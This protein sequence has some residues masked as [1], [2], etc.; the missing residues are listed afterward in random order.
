MTIP[1][2]AGMSWPVLSLCDPMIM[3]E[4][5]ESMSATVMRVSGIVS[6]CGQKPPSSSSDAV[7][8]PAG[9][10]AEDGWSSLISAT[11]AMIRSPTCTTWING[12]VTAVRRGAVGRVHGSTGCPRRHSLHRA[13]PHQKRRARVH[14]QRHSTCNVNTSTRCCFHRIRD[15]GADRAVSCEHPPEYS[16]HKRRLGSRDGFLVLHR[17]WQGQAP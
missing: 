15:T 16:C 2:I 7:A 5:G 9:V 17:P 13:G 3:E 11:W 6:P 8:D 10:R 14:E 12:G 4:G 1:S